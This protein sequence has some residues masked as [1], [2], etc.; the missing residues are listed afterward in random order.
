MLAHFDRFWNGQMVEAV[1]I[2]TL[3]E[4]FPKLPRT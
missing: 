3:I 1:N 2:C 4:Q